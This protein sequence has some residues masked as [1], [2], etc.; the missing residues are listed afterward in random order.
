MRRHLGFPGNRCQAAG[1]AGR[2]RVSPLGSAPPP[3]P[4]APRRLAGLGRAGPAAP[5]PRGPQAGPAAPGRSSRGSGRA[6]APPAAEDLNYNKMPLPTSSIM[7]GCLLSSKE[8][9]LVWAEIIRQK[10]ALIHLQQL[11]ICLQAVF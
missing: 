11:S 2:A 1:G 9:M 4:G 7:A 6:A 3:A 8:Q 5:A 10:I